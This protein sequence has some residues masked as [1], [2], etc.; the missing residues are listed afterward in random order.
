[1][2]NLQDIR[3]V[4]LGTPNIDAAARYASAVLGLE[5]E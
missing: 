1:M 5:Q 4:R 2:I 3:Y